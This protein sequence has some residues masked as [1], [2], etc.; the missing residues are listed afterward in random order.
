MPALICV[1]EPAAVLAVREDADFAGVPPAA[2]PVPDVGLE[3]AVERMGGNLDTYRHLFPVL[4]ND[5]ANMIGVAAGLLADGLRPEAGLM[6]RT[7]A[8]I[9]ETFGATALRAAATEAAASTEQGPGQDDDRLVGQVSLALLRCSLKLEAELR[10]AERAAQESLR[11]WSNPGSGGRRI[12]R[13]AIARR[14]V[15]A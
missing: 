8:G 1:S 10:V 7:L 2:K 5:A 3:Q 14:A 11:A 4:R 12:P 15:F 6:F 9:A 13:F